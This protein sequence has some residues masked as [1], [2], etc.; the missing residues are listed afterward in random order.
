MAIHYL[1]LMSQN[2]H[3]K[4]QSPMLIAPSPIV[5]WSD[6]NHPSPNVM[7]QGELLRMIDFRGDRLTGDMGPDTMKLFAGLSSLSLLCALGVLGHGLW[8]KSY[9]HYPTRPGRGD[10]CVL[11]DRRSGFVLNRP[12]VSHFCGHVYRSTLWLC[13]SCLTLPA[14]CLSPLPPVPPRVPGRCCCSVPCGCCPSASP[15]T[16]STCSGTRKPLYLSIPKIEVEHEILTLNPLMPKHNFN[17]FDCSHLDIHR[18]YNEEVMSCACSKGPFSCFGS[19]LS[20]MSFSD[21][22]S[23]AVHDLATKAHILTTEPFRVPLAG[24]VSNII[25]VYLH[26]IDILGS[27]VLVHA[28]QPNTSHYPLPA[29]N[30]KHRTL[31][32][33]HIA[34]LE[35]NHVYFT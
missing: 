2:Q 16:S 21:S 29:A 10:M 22:V 27:I 30:A 4:A 13:P 25:C 24:R 7:V 33:S 14:L 3:L 11:D 8:T 20:I 28:T 31:Y 23:Y 6:P 34:V 26:T 19:F 9:L 12:S 32:A 17:Q 18:T 1:N 35:P 5:M 15:S